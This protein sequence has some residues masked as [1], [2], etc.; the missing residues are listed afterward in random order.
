MKAECIDLHLGKTMLIFMDCGIKANCPYVGPGTMGGG[1]YVE[2][3]L[4]DPRP[5]LRERLGQQTRPG[6]EAGPLHQPVLRTEPLGYW[7]VCKFL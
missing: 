7:W 5:Y 3:C 4:R 2:V 1:H 6:L